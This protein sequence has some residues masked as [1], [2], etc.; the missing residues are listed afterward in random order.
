MPGHLLMCICH[1]SA[2]TESSIWLWDLQFCGCDSGNL[3]ARFLYKIM[4]SAQ[5][6]ER[7]GNRFII[8]HYTTGCNLA[9][10][11]VPTTDPTCPLQTLHQRLCTPSKP[12]PSQDADTFLLNTLLLLW[13]EIHKSSDFAMCCSRFTNYTGRSL[14]EIWWFKPH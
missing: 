8:F 3:S 14:A 5:A 11:P 4:Q 6:Q 7:K 12:Q 2:C 9:Q 13:E 10:A 1:Q